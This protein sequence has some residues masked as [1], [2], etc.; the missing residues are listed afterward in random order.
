MQCS[1]CGKEMME[2]DS[3]CPECGMRVKGEMTGKEAAPVPESAGHETAGAPEGTEAAPPAPEAA[4]FVPPPVP[5]PPPVPATRKPE[6]SMWAIASLV[7]G[8]GAFVFVPIICAILAIIFAVMAK[9]RIRK[10][11][12]GLGGSGFATAGLVLGILGLLLP[13]LLLIVAF[14]IFHH[15]VRPKLEAR[16]NVVV[17][18]EAADVYYLDN[19]FSYEG[20]TAAKLSFIEPEV[21]FDSAPG[22]EPEVVYIDEV[23]KDTVMLYCY[24]GRGDRYT[25]VVALNRRWKYNFDFD[26]DFIDGWSEFRRWYPFD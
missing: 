2:G 6:T 21:E 25:A 26:E 10:S 7:L 18:S 1:A 8:V 12:G 15:I 4:A 9:S 22:N 11:E 3:F 16:Y 5:P 14:P 24:S 20:L 13:I 17:G 23:D 19:D